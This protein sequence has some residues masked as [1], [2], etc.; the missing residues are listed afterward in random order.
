M[1]GIPALNILSLDIQQSSQ[2]SRIAYE[3]LAAFPQKSC[4]QALHYFFIHYAWCLHSPFW[5]ATGLI[6]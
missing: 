3:T 1:V 2:L 4:L 5:T 6:E